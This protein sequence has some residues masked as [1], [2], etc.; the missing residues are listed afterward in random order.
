VKAQISAETIIVV[1]AL[2]FVVSL[3]IFVF[4]DRHADIQR[5]KEQVLAQQLVDRIASFV[6]GI[7]ITGPD[8]QMDIYLPSQIAGEQYT[9][10]LSNHLIVVYTDRF[11]AS[12]PTPAALNNSVVV[13]REQRTIINDDG[14]ISIV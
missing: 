9:L 6:T 4:A 7:H 10:H 12:A 13:V 2:L 8:S 3:L 11:V 14:V 5:E 1:G